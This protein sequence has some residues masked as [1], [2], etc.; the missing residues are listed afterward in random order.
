[1]ALAQA[2]RDSL[3]PSQIITWTRG[4]GTAENLTGATLTGKIRDNVAGVVRDIAG[5]LTVTDGSAGVF[6]WAYHADDV[7]DAG[8][9]MVQFK[10]TFGDNPS[11]ARTI[12]S[13]W[14]VYE[15]F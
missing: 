8:R 9:F 4:D 13:E 2:I 14:F 6:A 10:A 3:R 5:T 11:P 7:A 1:M 15:A 12:A